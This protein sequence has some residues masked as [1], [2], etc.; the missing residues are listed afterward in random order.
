MRALLPV[1]GRLTGL[2]ALFQSLLLQRFSASFSASAVQA[3]GEAAPT[4]YTGTLVKEPDSNGKW[5]LTGSLEYTV[6]GRKTQVTLVNNRGFY[7]Y[8][9]VVRTSRHAMGCLLLRLGGTEDG[10][11][12]RQTAPS[13]AL[14]A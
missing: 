10:G 11:V 1:A 5:L 6:D 14:G 4:Q 13:P 3:Q 9:D 2:L 12:C 8:T 7:T